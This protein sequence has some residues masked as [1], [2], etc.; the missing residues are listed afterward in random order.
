MLTTSVKN[1]ANLYE[2]SVLYSDFDFVLGANNGPYIDEI[3]NL[4][5]KY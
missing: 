2:A 3:S 1:Q 5:N 4:W